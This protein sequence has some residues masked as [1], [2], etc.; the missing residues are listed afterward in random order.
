[1]YVCRPRPS[2]LEETTS[3]VSC[4]VNGKID[5]SERVLSS[6]VA[7]V[8]RASTTAQMSCRHHPGNC[9]YTCR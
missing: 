9:R 3:I 5:N 7:L 2:L 4:Y 8:K 1:M 6:R